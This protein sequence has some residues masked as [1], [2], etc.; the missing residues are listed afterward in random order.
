MRLYFLTL[1]PEIIHGYFNESMMKRALE[2]GV[3]T[4]EAIDIRDFA[5]NK[6]K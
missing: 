1:F 4:Y 5:E 3:I 6:H 2:N